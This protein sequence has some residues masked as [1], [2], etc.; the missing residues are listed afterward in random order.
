MIKSGIDHDAII[1]MFAQATAKQGE[2]LRR[3]VTTVVQIANLN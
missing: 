2:A 1:N 3:A